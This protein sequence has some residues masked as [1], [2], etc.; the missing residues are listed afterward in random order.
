MQRLSEGSNLSYVSNTEIVKI[1]K[2]KL[3]SMKI[4]CMVR[5][6]QFNQ[7]KIAKTI[8][9]KFKYIRNSTFAKICVSGR[10]ALS[11]AA[12]HSGETFI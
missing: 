2:I 7:M 3:V 11:A 12:P 10:G 6:L 5:T 1:F 8:R 4:V 9:T